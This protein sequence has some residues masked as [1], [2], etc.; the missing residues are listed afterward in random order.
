V[1][2]TFDPI[3]LLNYFAARWKFTAVSVA[4]ALT[5]AFAGCWLATNQYTA[6][7]TLLIEAPAASD[8][9]GGSTVSPIYLESLKSYEQF[10][11]GD[12]LF[13]KACEKFG[14]LSGERPP[15]IETLKRRVLRVTKLK[16]TKVLEISVTLPDPG[17]A[18]AVAQYI[19]SETEM[20]NRSLALEND[21][22][23]LASLREQLAESRNALNAARAEQARVMSRANPA[24]GQ[25]LRALTQV[26]EGLEEKAAETRT[27]VADLTAQ[28]AVLP[29]QAG[30]KD[31]TPDGQFVVQRLAGARAR[32]KEI[33]AERSSLEKRIAAK[34]SEVASADQRRDEVYARLSSVETAYRDVER[35]EAELS[36]SA[37]LRTEQLRI[38][39]PG[40]VPQRPSSPDIPLVL[41]AA[42]V[43]SL[44]ASLAWLALQYGLARQKER[45]ARR[46]IRVAKSASR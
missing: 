20:L 31:S 4:F 44:T 28:Q 19:A 25:E 38:V 26:A 43:W 8:P 35:R 2:D 40:I 13:L 18:Q 32:Q 1:Q 29:Q 3:S 21:K 15:A 30:L 12:S 33:E 46:E 9:R 42:L 6:T 22:R 27:E 39:D 16:D 11:S 45:F 17:K 10:A 37:G 24:L 41:A 23:A 7:A 34:S 14:L 5:A 36:A